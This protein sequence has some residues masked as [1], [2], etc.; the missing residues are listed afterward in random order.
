M[1]S[2][3]CCIL[4]S[5]FPLAWPP[6]AYAAPEPQGSRETQQDAWGIITNQAVTVAGQEFCKHFI[7]EWRDKPG[8]ERYTLAIGERPSARWGSQVWVEFAQRRLL[9]LQ[10]PPAR[11]GLQA[12]AA[13]A[14]D[15]VYES[16]LD[17]ERQRQ[18]V[19]DADL[20]RDEF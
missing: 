15:S 8:S 10:L 9:Q 2:K 16:I 7:A 1:M 17:I 19:H 18:L 3:T 5:I 11:A 20:A 6:V 12:L 14:A 4:F 13:S